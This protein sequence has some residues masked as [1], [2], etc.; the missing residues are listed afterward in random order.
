MYY[1]V[2]DTSIHSGCIGSHH[3]GSSSDCHTWSRTDN[4][5]NYLLYIS[6]L[7]GLKCSK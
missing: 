3:L 5:D 7:Y 4:R 1:V 2:I 6:L